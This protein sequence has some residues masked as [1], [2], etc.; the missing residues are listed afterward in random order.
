MVTAWAVGGLVTGRERQQSLSF[1]N[2]NAP[3]ARI[4][5]VPTLTLACCPSLLV[6]ITSPA[7]TLPV[8]LRG[9]TPGTRS[10]PCCYP[11][12]RLF[13]HPRRKVKIPI[14]YT[15]YLR[16]TSK[17]TAQGDSQSPSGQQVLGHP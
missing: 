16:A 12:L 4:P 17:R 9:G 1:A 8:L 6:K 3:A 2:Q 11:S 15:R 14:T 7:P 10:K 13:I 5:L